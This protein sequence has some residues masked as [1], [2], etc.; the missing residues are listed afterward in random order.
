[1]AISLICFFLVFLTYQLYAASYSGDALLSLILAS[2][3][4]FIP[5]AVIKK[6]YIVSTTMSMKSRLASM[7]AACHRAFPFGDTP[8]SML[9]Q[10]QVPFWH[11]M[12]LALKYDN[13]LSTISSHSGQ[14]PLLFYFLPSMLPSLF[15]R[16][17]HFAPAA[18]GANVA[19]SP[20]TCCVS[21]VGLLRPL[22]SHSLY[23]KLHEGAE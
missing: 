13:A 14:P 20:S 3:S 7:E 21:N 10:I 12:F 22:A 2:D 8:H 5:V 15:P 9:C 18:C 6:V 11:V 19:S 16:M 4:P 17:F 1:M 23:E